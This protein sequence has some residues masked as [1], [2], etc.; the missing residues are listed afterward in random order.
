MR[1]SM[2]IRSW[3][4]SVYE[5]IQ[6]AE[7]Q[8][9]MRCVVDRRQE[10]FHKYEDYQDDKESCPDKKAHLGPSAVPF[11]VFCS[12]QCLKNPLYGRYGKKRKEKDGPEY[13]I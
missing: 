6:V 7:D 2:A 9:N 8:R 11:K 10:L 1:N 13:K 4:A 12:F 5:L 3:N